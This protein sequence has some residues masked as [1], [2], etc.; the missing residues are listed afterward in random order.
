MLWMIFQYKDRQTDRRKELLLEVLADLKSLGYVLQ[1]RTV[2]K[3]KVSSPD[4]YAMIV[5]D[6][7]SLFQ[8][9][10]LPDYSEDLP[11]ALISCNSDYL[12]YSL[13]STPMQMTWIGDWRVEWNGADTFQRFQIFSRSR[14]NKLTSLRGLNSC[15]FLC[16]CCL[17]YSTVVQQHSLNQ[18]IQESISLTNIVKFSVFQRIAFIYLQTRK[19]Q[20]TESL[21][22]GISCDIV[23]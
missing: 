13:P 10:S 23:I 6:K 14:I 4:D 20:R 2:E 21:D 9:L 19:L 22:S 18:L 1:T 11:R 5:S 7:F 16:R 12:N 15:L 17:L 3:R 8:E